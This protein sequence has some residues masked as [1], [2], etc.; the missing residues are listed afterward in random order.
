MLYDG[1]LEM[2]RSESQ[3]QWTFSSSMQARSRYLKKM[4]AAVASAGAGYQPPS[5]EKLRSSLLVDAVG[6][7]DK[8]LIKL[9][10]NV[11]QYGSTITSDGWTDARSRP[12]LNTLQVFAN[13][14]KFVD[15]ID[16]SGNTKV[17]V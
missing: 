4:L 8:E 13:G 15:S 6:Q 5:C 9:E 12:I 3:L 7:V 16:T 10:V 11:E 1:G 2:L 17:L 14:A